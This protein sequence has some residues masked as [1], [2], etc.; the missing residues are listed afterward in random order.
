MQLI[1]YNARECDPKRCTAMRLYRAG[2]IKMVY[3]LQ[4]LPSGAILLDPFAE[5]ALSKAD[6]E[7]LKNRGV[8]AL[9]CSWKRIKHI[10]RL[11]GRMVPRALPYLV[12][13]NPTYYGRPTILSTAEALAAALFIL[14]EKG[15]AEDILGLFKW[16]PTFFDL[17][18]E[19]LEAYARATDSAE[20]V[21]LQRQFMS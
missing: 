3:N 5:K 1:V 8:V 6:A 15:L 21:A 20:V 13:T 19:P 9:D 14:G 4:E 2:K 16:G 10:L 12:A 18:R 17:N 11:R 7:T